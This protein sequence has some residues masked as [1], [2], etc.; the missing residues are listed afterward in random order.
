MIQVILNGK[1]N[2]SSF[3]VYLTVWG[4]LFTGQANLCYYKY[5]KLVG[6]FKSRSVTICQTINFM[7]C[8][9]VSIEMH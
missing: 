8:D 2:I 4:I 6:I 5:I 1:P 3:L 7:Y 9:H